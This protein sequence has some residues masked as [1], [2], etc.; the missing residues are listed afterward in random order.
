[1]LR[2]YHEL[3][4]WQKSYAF[5]LAIYRATKGFP[6]HEAFG[7]T[8]QLRRAAVSVPANIA[9]GYCRR[10]RADYLRFLSI[11]QGS[12]GELET[13]VSLARDLSYLPGP[14]AQELAGELT[15]VSKMLARLR[16]SLSVGVA[17]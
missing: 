15:E 10:T 4:V 3:G 12:V 13:L 5:A 9:E 17:R 14:V 6:S 1:V 16:Q 11:A 8:S 7:L 2:S